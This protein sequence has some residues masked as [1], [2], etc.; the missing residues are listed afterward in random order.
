MIGAFG[1]VRNGAVAGVARDMIVGRTT[2]QGDVAS[3][4]GQRK[5]GESERS[6]K[7]DGDEG[8]RGIPDNSFCRTDSM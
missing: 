3:S 7:H 1:N 6:E 4:D 5:R 2:S 8:D